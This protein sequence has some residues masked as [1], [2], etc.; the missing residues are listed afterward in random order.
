MADLREFSKILIFKNTEET[1]FYFGT[2]GRTPSETAFPGVFGYKEFNGSYPPADIL[3]NTSWNA[4]TGQFAVLS[5]NLLHSIGVEENNSLGFNIAPDSSGTAI[6][7]GDKLYVGGGSPSAWTY[8]EETTFQSN[9]PSPA[10]AIG[11][12]IFWGE[13]PNNLKLGGKIK[14]IYAVGS[15][16]YT[17]GARY[18]FEKS[19]DVAFPNN[20]SGTYVGLP[21]PQDIYYYRKTW[22]GKG[23]KTDITEGFFVLIGVELENNQRAV[24]PWLDPNG[25]GTSDT[26]I[27]NGQYAFTDLIRVKRISNRFKSDETTEDAEE[28]IPCSIQRTNWFTYGNGPNTLYKNTDQVP[29]WLAYFV[30]PYAGTPS[31]L[32][33]NTT[34]VIEVNE[35]LPAL[36]KSP[37]ANDATLYNYAIQGVI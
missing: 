31:I 2:P 29:F 32:D 34:Y 6:I 24:Y 35:R 4:D 30:N 7:V 17:N 18:Q 12:Y 13:D 3:T 22:N 1:R 27:V 19:M 26:K 33:K 15:A 8:D 36:I 14:T 20:T 21:A 9:S 10:L 28:L 37:Q 25:T 16:E 5:R 23:L 11:D